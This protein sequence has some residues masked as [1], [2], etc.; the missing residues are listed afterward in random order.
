MYLIKIVLISHVRVPPCATICIMQS[1]TVYFVHPC[2]NLLQFFPW[3]SHICILLFY[4]LNEPECPDIFRKCIKS[5]FIE[6]FM[7]ITIKWRSLHLLKVLLVLHSKKAPHTL[8]SAVQFT[9]YLL[10]GRS[11]SFFNLTNLI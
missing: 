3:F 6:C 4:W 1:I 5:I 7:L 10:C 8:T 11:W 9:F 2:I